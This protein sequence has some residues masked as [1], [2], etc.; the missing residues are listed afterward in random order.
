MKYTINDLQY[1]GTSE[2]IN[3]IIELNKQLEIIKS[4]NKIN[5]GVK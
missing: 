2:L 5:R 4:I 1:W 3:E